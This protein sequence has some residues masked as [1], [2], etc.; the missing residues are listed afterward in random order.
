MDSN[1]SAQR[2]AE[3]RAAAL[4]NLGWSVGAGAAIWAR[5]AEDEL[6][7][8]VEARETFSSGERTR[9]TWERIH[10]TALM[11]I[12]AV[13]QVLAFE[14]RVR[15]LTGDAELQ[16]ARAAFDAQVPDAEALRDLVAH[17]D[18]YAT[19]RG[20]RQRGLRQP[21][22]ADEYLSMLLYWSG[23]ETF[24]RLGT[25]EIA[26]GRAAK[27]SVQLAEKVE[28]VRERQ[29]HLAEAAANAA[30]ARRRSQPSE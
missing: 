4:Y 17:L 13:D 22:I 23:G 2:A 3:H 12:V 15:R 10:A 14:Q 6:A 20:Q 7:R 16:K 28:N 5:A 18:E 24:V 27:A 19:G 26:L 30:L 21:P 29:L 9:E 11:L 1:E 25:D 8:H